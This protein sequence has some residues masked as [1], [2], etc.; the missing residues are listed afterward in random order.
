MIQRAKERLRL[1]LI[2]DMILTLGTVVQVAILSMTHIH[3]AWSIALAIVTAS[4]R[5]LPKFSILY[6]SEKEI[7]AYIEGLP[8]EG[9]SQEPPVQ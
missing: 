4:G 8:P 1:I 3:Y 9:Q 7:E 6:G 2:G 5:L